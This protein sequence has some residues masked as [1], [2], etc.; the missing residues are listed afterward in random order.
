M[1][2]ANPLGITDWATCSRAGFCFVFQV[3]GSRLHR[4]QLAIALNLCTGQIVAGI[5]VSR[6]LA[7]PMRMQS[8]LVATHKRVPIAGLHPRDE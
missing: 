4:Q 1:K 2:A 5:A 3:V 7:L 6:T 8:A